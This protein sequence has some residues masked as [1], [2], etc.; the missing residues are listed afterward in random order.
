MNSWSSKPDNFIEAPVIIFLL[1]FQSVG[2]ANLSLLCQIDSFLANCTYD[3]I[4]SITA[5]STS[6]SANV[7]VFYAIRTAKIKY[8]SR[9]LKDV[10][11]YVP[12]RSAR[13]GCNS[14]GR[15]SSPN[16]VRVPVSSAYSAWWEGLPLGV[17]PSRTE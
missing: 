1:L 8:R 4:I 2:L 7:L 6:N 5:T 3:Y 17:G 10:P 9:E 13:T 11:P 12:A 16:P 14:S 15:L